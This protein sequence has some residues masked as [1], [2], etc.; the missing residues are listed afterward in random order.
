MNTF[1]HPSKLKLDELRVIARAVPSP[2]RWA[3]VWFLLW[4]EPQYIEYKSQQAVD[5]A[6]RQYKKRLDKT[7]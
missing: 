3:A 6:I 2:L 4:I 5:D 1:L 7:K